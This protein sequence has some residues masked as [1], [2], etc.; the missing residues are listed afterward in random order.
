MRS[1][2]AQYGQLRRRSVARGRS[3]GDGERDVDC[4]APQRG[5]KL[6]KE[7]ANPNVRLLYNVY[8][9]QVETGNGLGLIDAAAEHTAVFHVADSPGRHDPVRSLVKAVD[10]MRGD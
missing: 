8:H 1:R 5:L 10:G 4:R 3:G 7:V 2:E 6:V 9:E